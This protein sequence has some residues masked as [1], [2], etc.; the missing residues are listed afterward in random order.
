VDTDPKLK[1][2]ILRQIAVCLSK[3]LLNRHRTLNGIYRARKLRQHAVPSRVG[4]PAAVLG[5]EPVHHFAS[6]RQGA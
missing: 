3:P 6:R 4:Y 5:D 2:T 1:P